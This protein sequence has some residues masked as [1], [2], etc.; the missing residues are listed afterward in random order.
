MKNSADTIIEI[1]VF[2]VYWL[3]FLLQIYFYKENC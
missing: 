1:E 3:F 2:D